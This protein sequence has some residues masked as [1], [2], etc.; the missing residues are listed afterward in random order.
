MHRWRQYTPYL[1]LQRARQYTLSSHHQAFRPSKE[2][3]R[4]RYVLPPT[5]PPKNILEPL[6]GSRA[7][8]T[9]GARQTWSKSRWHNWAKN[10][11]YIV[12]GLVVLG[13]GTVIFYCFLSQSV[14]ITGRRRLDYV[15]DRITGFEKELREAQG[16]GE[17]IK[18]VTNLSVG[19]E[20][21]IMQG[22]ISV[23]NR[24]IHA[25]GLDNQ[26]WEFRIVNAPCK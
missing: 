10:H 20:D 2:F 15:P 19:S 7:Y 5:V 24:L 11:K 23:F 6:K 26:K 1:H 18:K 13:S 25:S 3:K 4:S 14:P 17:L 9:D 12:R 8:Q 21:P 16:E 22:P